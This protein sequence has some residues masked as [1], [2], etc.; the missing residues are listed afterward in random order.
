MSKIETNKPVTIRYYQRLF[1][2]VDEV[3][4]GKVTKITD[5]GVYVTV[6][7]SGL[8]K[9]FLSIQCE[10]QN[11]LPWRYTLISQVTGPHIVHLTKGCTYL[12]IT[13]AIGHK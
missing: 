9:S 1:P 10:P 4:I 12:S 5:I 13:C 6:P 3:V 8:T 7:H 2:E 11:L